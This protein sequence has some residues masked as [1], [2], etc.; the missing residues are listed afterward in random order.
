MVGAEGFPCLS[1]RAH[2]LASKSL[3]PML[4]VSLVYIGFPLGAHLLQVSPH[5]C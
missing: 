3:T 2:E 5:A 1:D 4:R